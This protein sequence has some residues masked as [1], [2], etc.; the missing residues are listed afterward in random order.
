MAKPTSVSES[1]DPGSAATTTRTASAKDVDLPPAL[2]KRGPLA[3][4]LDDRLGIAGLG[5]FGLRYI[6]PNHWSFLIGEIAMWSFVVLLLTGVFLTIW[7]KPSMAEVEYNGSY[8]LMKGM[9]M[10]QAFESTIHISMDIRGG[11]LLRQMHHW[12]ALLFVASAFAHAARVFFTGAFRKPREI[13]WI[14]GVGLLFLGTMA[15]FS[16]YSLPDDLLSGTGLRFADGLMRSIPLIG[17][18]VEFFTF[19]GEFPGDLIVSRLYMVHILLIPALILGLLAVHVG[20]VAYYKHT[21]FPGPGRTETNAVGEPAFPVYTAKAGGLFFLVFGVIALFGALVTINPVWTYGPYNPAQ[22]TAGSQP[23]WYM[24]W[25]EGAVRIM[26]GWESHWGHTTWSWNIFIPGVILLGAFFTLMALWPW[27]EAWFTGDTRSHNLLERPQDN[28]TRTAFGVAIITLM[29]LLQFGG[30]NDLIATHFKLS[31]NAISWFLRIAIFV[32]P[33]IAFWV[34]KRICLGK[35]NTD[36]ERLLHG[37][38]T[39]DMRRNAEGGYVEDHVEISHDEAFTLTSTDD[40]PVLESGSDTDARGVQRNGQNVSKARARASRWWAE[41]NIPHPTR[42]ELEEAHA[43][44]GA[45]QDA[46]HK[47]EHEGAAET[48]E[49]EGSEKH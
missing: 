19:N 9:M 8:Q 21:Q 1:R 42:E 6:F 13:Q 25:V 46:E 32:V 16:G 41:G 45:E 39:G 30:A 26:P 48:R 18:W 40:A 17:T 12:A 38:P 7:F 3:G 37:S 28:P 2:V 36:H 24:G 15:G 22:V 23:D 20:L 31:L 44:H 33:V 34:T 5:K 27:I 47:L 35:K 29:L 43:H 10:S 11:L 4:W 49:L 14:L